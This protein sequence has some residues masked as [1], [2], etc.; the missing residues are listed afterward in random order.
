MCT[1]AIF[2]CA[3][4][5]APCVLQV[6]P[7][8]APGFNVPAFYEDFVAERRAHVHSKVERNLRRIAAE[9][10]RQYQPPPEHSSVG[11]P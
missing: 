2:Y 10:K 1:C 5:F 7:D 3:N 6:V 9:Q 4:F 11:I 8:V